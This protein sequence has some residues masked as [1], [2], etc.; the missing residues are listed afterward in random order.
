ML[1]FTILMASFLTFQ[2][3]C[4]I[5]SISRWK[6]VI[7]SRNCSQSRTD[8]F[9][10]WTKQ[11]ELY[12]WS[13]S[14]SLCPDLHLEIYIFVPARAGTSPVSKCSGGLGGVLVSE[15]HTRCIF[16]AF[17]TSWHL[18]QETGSCSQLPP[19]QIFSVHKSSGPHAG[20]QPSDVR[21]GRSSPG[22]H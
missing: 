22:C 20:F 21:G 3:K 1:S 5:S 14:G 16:L 12:S 6:Q 10:K 11:S 19:W 2:H 17:L 8:S 18:P 15:T 13:I 4:E 9:A 7:S